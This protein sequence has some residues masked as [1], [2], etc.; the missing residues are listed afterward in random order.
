MGGR[1]LERLVRVVLRP[2]YPWAAYFA[3]FLLP[4]QGLGDGDSGVEALLASPPQR[5][6]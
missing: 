1:G 2:L 5:G 6:R 4:A 3:H